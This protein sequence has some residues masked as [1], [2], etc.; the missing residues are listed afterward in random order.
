[1]KKYQLA[2]IFVCMAINLYCQNTVIYSDKAPKPIGPYSQAILSGQTLYIS[3]QIPISTETGLTDT[4][5]I[6]NETHLVLKHI[7]SILN[8][9]KM[10]YKDVVKATIYT[11]DLKNFAKINEIYSQYFI[12]N[13]PARETVQIS[14][15]PKNVHIEIS[16]IAIKNAE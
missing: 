11:T 13:P 12:S 1:M 6:E 3:G 14:R 4:S 15:L 2:V 16:V 9:A 8:A 10:E 5:S 7:G